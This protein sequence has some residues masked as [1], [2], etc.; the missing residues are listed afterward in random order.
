MSKVA[1]C[2]WFDGE[3]EAA[4]E[5]YVSAFLACGQDAAVGDVMR[6]AEGGPRPAGSVLTATFRLAGQ[7]FIALNGGPH[8]TFSPAISLFVRCADQDEVDRFWERLSDGGKTE[9]CGWLTDRF[10]VSWQ[11]V[12]T[13]LGAML[14]DA[15]PARAGRVMQALMQMT[16]LDVAALRRAYDGLAA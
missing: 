2:L 13:A 16:K 9:R 12:P 8:F 4:A 11:V 14:Q 7:E 6:Y 15:D 1:P 10:G 5:F 3:A